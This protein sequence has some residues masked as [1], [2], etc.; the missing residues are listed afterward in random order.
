MRIICCK[1]ENKYNIWTGAARDQTPSRHCACRSKTADQV[2][3]GPADGGR[4]LLFYF[5]VSLFFLKSTANSDPTYPDLRG[6]TRYF[7]AY[8]RKVSIV[9]PLLPSSNRATSARPRSGFRQATVSTR[10]RSISVKRRMG[11]C[12]NVFV[13]RHDRGRAD[14]RQIECQVDCRGRDKTEQGRIV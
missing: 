3:S 10:R 4:V 9:R 11:V 2:G 14:H 1:I 7:S 6:I 12:G 13:P 8:R 5:K